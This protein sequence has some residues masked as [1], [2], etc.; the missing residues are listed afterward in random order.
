MYQAVFRVHGTGPFEQVT[1]TSGAG[2]ELWCN[3]HCDLLHLDG[4]E[5]GEVL[6]H[7]RSTVGVRQHVGG[8]EDSVVIT[9]SC[10][11]QRLDDPIERYLAAHDCLSLPP[12]RYAAGAK[13]VR[14]LALTPENLTSFYRAVA[15]DH[16]VVVE[17][18]RRLASVATSAPLLSVD[19]VLP[20]LS[21]RQHE[22]F[23]TA[24]EQGYYE[25]PRETTTAAI[26]DAVGIERRTAE[27]HLRR[28]EKKI[29]DAVVEYL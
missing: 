9:E 19:S 25:L 27:D 15:A 5:D 24:H 23:L 11:K 16:S 4:D 29:A 7:I 21:P 28:A 12:L 1:A 8:D 6:E 26:A 2:I 14:V 17:S 22:V 13:I 20:T 3:D 18:K 10:L